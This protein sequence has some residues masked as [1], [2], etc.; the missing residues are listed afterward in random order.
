MQD[1]HRF[2]S[3]QRRFLGRLGKHAVTRDQCGSDLPGEDGQREIPRADA[4]HW[5]QRAGAAIH[6]PPRLGRIVAQ[7]IDC[8]THFGNGI[9]GGLARLAD[10]QA[11]QGRHPRLHDV[12][13]T[14]ETGGAVID[15]HHAPRP[16]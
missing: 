13:R 3:D 7:E 8:F 14:V 4:Y 11:E 1:A 5:P 10:D 15:G 12:G 6:R 16:E 9:G 2:G